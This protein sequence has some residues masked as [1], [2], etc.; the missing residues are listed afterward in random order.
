[1]ADAYAHVAGIRDVTPCAL[2]CEL[3]W[4]CIFSQ[5]EGGPGT[6]G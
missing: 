5:R 3:R 1:M 2:G 4:A 6:A